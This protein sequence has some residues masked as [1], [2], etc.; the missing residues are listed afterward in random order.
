MR[1]THS[2]TIINSGFA[3]PGMANLRHGLSG[4]FGNKTK[5][6]QGKIAGFS[7][8]SLQAIYMGMVHTWQ[9]LAEVEK[10]A[11]GCSF[12]SGLALGPKPIFQV[13]E[14]A[15]ILIA[16]QAPGQ[17]THHKGIPFDDPSGDRLRTWLGVPRDSFYNPR[18]FAILPMGFCYPGKGT[19]GDLPP[20]PECAPAWR[21][22]FLSRL[23]DIQLTLVIGTYATRWHLPDE[24]GKNLQETVK[25][26]QVHFPAFCHCRT[27]AHVIFA[28]FGRTRGLKRMCCL[29]LK[30][31]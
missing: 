8:V 3:T 23:P 20:R 2:V 27:Q 7:Y 16:G 29:R 22:A 26:W 14:S 11:R 21:Q 24:K 18:H 15:K 30:P 19:S 12:C 1:M 31:A 4:D 25:G 28:G 6:L 5:P 17:R 13:H 9:N 10:A